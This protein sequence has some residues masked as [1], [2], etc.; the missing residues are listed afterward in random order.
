MMH[1]YIFALIFL[2]LLVGCWNLEVD[3]VEEWCE[4]ISGVDLIEKYSPFWAG[5]PMVTLNPEAIRDDF[6]GFLNASLLEKVEHRAQKDGVAGG[7]GPS[8]RE[9]VSAAYGY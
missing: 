4:Q 9:H 1:R 8:H 2:S 3:T 5:I 6:V 7:H